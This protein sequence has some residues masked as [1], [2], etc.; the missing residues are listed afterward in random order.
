MM[1]LGGRI[2]TTYYYMPTLG[3]N[4]SKHPLYEGKFPRINI[5]P[6]T[7]MGS[8]SEST[9]EKTDI[10]LS[11]SCDD[12]LLT[13]HTS[14][15]LIRH[16]IGNPLFAG[17]PP[18]PWIAQKPHVPLGSFTKITPKM[19]WLAEHQLEYVS[20]SSHKSPHHSSKSVFVIFIQSNQQFSI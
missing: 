11:N 6:Q 4:F 16:I 3:A 12:P 8:A 18:S 13:N 15:K 20:R 10:P 19:V 7:R 1:L 2:I 14:P 9:M 17:R 5:N